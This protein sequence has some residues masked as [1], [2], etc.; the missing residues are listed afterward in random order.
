[1]C[2]PLLVFGLF[3]SCAAS[4]VFVYPVKLLFKN[5]LPINELIFDDPQNNSKYRDV[6]PLKIIRRRR[7]EYC[8]T[9][10]ETKS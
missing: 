5:F 4:F 2:N 1:M 9:I 10:L 6:A 3:V 7:S 8:R